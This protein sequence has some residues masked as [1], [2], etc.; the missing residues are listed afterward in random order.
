MSLDEPEDKEIKILTKIAHYNDISQR[1]LAELR[2]IASNQTQDDSDDIVQKLTNVLAT[3]SPS[4]LTEYD[5]LDD[6]ERCFLNIYNLKAKKGYVVD[7]FRIDNV[8]K[9]YNAWANDDLPFADEPYPLFCGKKLPKEEVIY[10]SGIFVCIRKGD[11]HILGIIVDRIDND[12]YQICDAIPSKKSTLLMY[13]VNKNDIIPMPQSLPSSLETVCDFEKDE[14]ILSLWCER[15]VWTTEF[16]F[17]AIADIPKK[18]EDPYLVSFFDED[19][20]PSLIPA[21]YIVKVP[22]A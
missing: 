6:L 15:G 3:A 18:R 1:A 8:R 22:L 11:K 7:G 2:E 9:M 21:K 4:L 16:Y 14:T 5:L 12:Y 17:A 13:K 20:P 10:P 19:G